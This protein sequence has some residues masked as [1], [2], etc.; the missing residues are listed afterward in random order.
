MPVDQA[1]QLL[2]RASS[3]LVLTGAGISAESGVPTFRGPGGLWKSFRPEELATPEAFAR[4]PRLCWE[5]YGWRRQQLAECQPN[6]AHLALARWMLGRPGV[7]LVTQN[8]DGLHEAA[9][10]AV[11]GP[12]DPSPAFPLRLHGSIFAV[13]CPGCGHRA[14]HRDPIDARSAATLPRCPICSRVVRPDVVWFGEMLPERELRVAFDAAARAGACLV[15]GTTGA[16]YPAAQL[17]FDAHR[18]G[19]RVVVVDPGET[20]FDEVADL[21]FRNAAGLL[22]PVLLGAGH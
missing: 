19:S 9:A 18:G 22:L 8:V 14:E 17:V 21:R 15:V 5:W 16:V 1:R 6:A 3:I 2:A 20:A 11:A 10:R 13:R 4:D 7:T 12:A